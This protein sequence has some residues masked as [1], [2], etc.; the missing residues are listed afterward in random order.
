MAEGK[1]AEL[2]TAK[3]NVEQVPQ[4]TQLQ[5]N[6]EGMKEKLIEKVDLEAKIANG[7]QEKQQFETKLQQYIALKEKLTQEA[8]QGQKR[9]IKP[10]LMSR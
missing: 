1:E 3:Q 8:Q 10:V 2:K 5:F 6:L 4:L 7:L 9:L